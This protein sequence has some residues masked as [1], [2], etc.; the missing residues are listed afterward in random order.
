PP[1]PRP[2]LC[3]IERQAHARGW[4]DGRSAVRRGLAG[5][6]RLVSLQ[7]RLGRPRQIRRI[8]AVLRA[9]LQ[10]PRGVAELRPQGDLQ[11]IIDANVERELCPAVTRAIHRITAALPPSSPTD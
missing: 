6:Y 2:P 3:A 9:E 11:K 4:L 5:Y 1:R 8:S 10:R 7:S